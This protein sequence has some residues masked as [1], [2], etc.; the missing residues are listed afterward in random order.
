V[1]FLIFWQCLRNAHINAVGRTQLQ[2]SGRQVWDFDPL[3][4]DNVH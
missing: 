2:C 4:S 1:R 3:H